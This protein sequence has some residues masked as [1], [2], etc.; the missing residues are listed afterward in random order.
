[1]DNVRLPAGRTVGTVQA[2]AALGAI[3]IATL[4]GLHF[5]PG[6]GGVDPV[7]QL[8]SEYPLQDIG[9]GVAFVVALL[10]ANAAAALAGMVMAR[11]GLLRD[12][13]TT[14]LFVISC[15]SLLG[16]TVFLKDPAG[17]TATWSG[18]L[19][20]VCTIVT[21][22]SQY[23]L[24][25]VLWWRY[26]ADPLW[27]GRARAVGVLAV[28][29]SVALIPFVVV[30]A[31]RSGTDKFAGMAIGLVERYMFVVI[32]VM[33]VVLTSWAKAMT[34]DAERERLVGGQ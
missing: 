17:A 26:R 20:Q 34:R 24:A 33:M 8:L 15:A 12:R 28:A 13:T 31:T 14:A 29:E 25:V 6:S 18:T 11:S 32:L 30:F 21:C 10:S 7:Y 16:L 4:V 1:M 27:N 2:A 19:H 22:V 23:L 9:V 3:G 5:L